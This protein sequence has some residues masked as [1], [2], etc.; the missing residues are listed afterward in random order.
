MASSN[1]SIILS[2]SVALFLVLLTQANSTNVFSF[3][4]QSFDSSNLILQGD[5]TVSSAGQLRLTKV[6]GN[7]KPTP[8]SLGRAF[9][10]APIQIWDSTTGSVASFATS[11]TF[12]IFA[13]NKSSTADGLAFA[14]VPVGSEPKSNAGYL[15]LFDNAT[16]DSSAQTVAVEFDTYSNPKWDPEPRHIGIDVNSIESIRW[17][18]WGL[19]NGQNAEILITY[20][21][22]TQL[23]VASLVHPSRRA[24]YIVS[25]RV[26]LKSVLPEW[27]T[28][29]FSATTGLLDGSTETHDVH[30]WSFASKL[31]DGITSGGIDLA[32]FVLNKFI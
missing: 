23:L 17:A 5:A 1:F 24:S 11:F 19:A 18:S 15:G 29:G 16:Y 30:S 4:F 27:V 7:G 8:A 3:N 21:A 9:Y 20:D 28:I 22:S 10:S 14:L 6:K 26:D 25:E 31:S 12:K 32:K 13:P 2:L